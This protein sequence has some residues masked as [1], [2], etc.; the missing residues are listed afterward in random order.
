MSRIPTARRFFR[1]LARAAR[2]TAGFLLL[3]ALVAVGI[4]A[5][6][7]SVLPSGV[8]ISRKSVQTSAGVVGARLV[9]EAVMTNEFSGPRLT[10][11]ANKGTLDGYEWA[12]LVRPNEALQGAFPSRQW[13][14]YDVIVQVPV[15]NGPLV[16]LET[17]RLGRGR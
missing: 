1:R 17:V 8:V 6:I 5:F 11:G 7:L 3:E 13:T 2:P 16:T 9:A 14:A 4:M 15:P 10:A 12:T